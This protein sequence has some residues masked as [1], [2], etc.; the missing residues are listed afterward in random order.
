MTFQKGD[1]AL[2]FGHNSYW[3]GTV[4]KI[5]SSHH[6]DVFSQITGYKCKIV[7]LS[8]AQLDPIRSRHAIGD[9]IQQWSTCLLV[10]AKNYLALCTICAGQC[11]VT[12]TTNISTY[13]DCSGCGASYLDHGFRTAVD[14]SRLTPKT[15]AAWLAP[16]KPH[17]QALLPQPAR[18]HNPHSVADNYKKLKAMGTNYE[19]FCSCDV[20]NFGCSCGRTEWE[21]SNG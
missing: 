9:D 10:P 11:T 21:K 17:S 4:V 2:L 16:T 3:D 20:F 6:H 1:I 19:P 18:S 15:K 7:A 5:T 12:V 14:A 8:S 13:W